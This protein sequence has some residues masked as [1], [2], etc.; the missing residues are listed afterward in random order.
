M[1]NI[2]MID[3]EEVHDLDGRTGG[4]PRPQVQPGGTGGSGFHIG[5]FKQ[6]YKNPS[7][8]SLVREKRF[9]FKPTNRS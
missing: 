5:P 9:P 8:Q 3:T 6:L 1:H 4:A 7:R 2:Y